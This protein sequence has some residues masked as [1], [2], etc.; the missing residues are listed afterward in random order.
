MEKFSAEKYLNIGSALEWFGNEASQGRWNH[1]GTKEMAGRTAER[2][3]SDLKEIGCKISAKAAMRFSADISGIKEDYIQTRVRE[4][5]DVIY[6]EM[7][8]NLFLWIPPERAKYYGYPQHTKDWDETQRAIEGPIAGRFK[9]ASNEIFS[10]RICYAVAQ[11]TACVFHLMRACE[12]GIKAIYKTLGIPAPRLSDSWGNLLRPMD[13][14]LK[15]KP[16]DR[17]GDWAKYPE[18]FD[19]ATNDVRSIKRT[20]RDST[21]HVEAAYDEDSARK[22]LDAVTSFFVT[23]S[24]KLDQDGNVHNKPLVFP[25]T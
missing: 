8:E 1:L 10:A 11:W 21:M 4:L 23:L 15:K 17:Y 22:A 19:H 24:K 13:E 12:V 3:S 2:L 18:F 5:K 25:R 14:Q 16:E 6:S 9:T 20:W 7:S